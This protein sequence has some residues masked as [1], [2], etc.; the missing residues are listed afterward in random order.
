[1]VR[2]PS[3]ET[4]LVHSRILHSKTL[5]HTLQHEAQA[6]TQHLPPMWLGFDSRTGV[7][8]GF[9]GSRPRSEGFSPGSPVFIL[10]QKP[11]LLNSN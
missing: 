10:L 11:T 9:V 3:L 8:G 5:K 2:I 6:V 1:M 7:I 4:F